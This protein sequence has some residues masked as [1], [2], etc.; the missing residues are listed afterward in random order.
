M[1]IMIFFFF[2]PSIPLAQMT[3][4]FV[5]SGA[6]RG[7]GWRTV[8]VILSSQNVAVSSLSPSAV[9]TLDFCVYLELSPENKCHVLPIYI[10]KIEEHNN[11]IYKTRF[12]SKGEVFCIKLLLLLDESRPD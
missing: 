7:D 4:T 8:I 1:T 2:L 5:H 11:N 6:E 9:V 3:S 10:N 12:R